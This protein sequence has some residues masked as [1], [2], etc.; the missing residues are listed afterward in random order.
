[1]KLSLSS[2]F[3][4]SSKKHKTRSISRSDAPSFGS[5]TTASSEYGSTP[6]SVLPPCDIKIS[7]RDAEAV[8]RRFC[9]DP[10]TEEEVAALEAAVEELA[11][12]E[13]S[14]ALEE[15]REAFDVF[16]VDG[17]GRI[18]P[19]ELLGVF[20]AIGDEECTIKD[21]RRM[22]AGVDTNGDGFVGFDDF[23]RMMRCNA[24]NGWS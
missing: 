9:P 17:D 3:P 15:I 2:F 18:S 4:N 20:V 13:A 5:V 22:I 6:K 19:E 16:D 21:C 24:R 7:R 23:V 11:A 8:L 14:A 12:G 1:M 10:P